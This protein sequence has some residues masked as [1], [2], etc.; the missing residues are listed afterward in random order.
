MKSLTPLSHLA[1]PV[2]ADLGAES[3]SGTLSALQQCAPPD[4]AGTR[5]QTTGSSAAEQ[6]KAYVRVIPVAPGSYVG[7]L[8]QAWSRANTK[9]PSIYHQDGQELWNMLRGLGSRQMLNE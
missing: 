9:R 4:S 6:R 5:A 1:S 3:V 2:A 7:R 8:I